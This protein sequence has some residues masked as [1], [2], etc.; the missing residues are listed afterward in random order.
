MGATHASPDC[1]IP[2]GNWDSFRKLTQTRIWAAAA[3]AEPRPGPRKSAS[4]WLSWKN[5]T[6][7]CSPP[8]T[9]IVPE[10]FLET[11]PEYDIGL[12]LQAPF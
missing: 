1:R 3:A 11:H 2:S 4:V 10:R 6:A 7:P 12:G 5:P 8:G 9:I